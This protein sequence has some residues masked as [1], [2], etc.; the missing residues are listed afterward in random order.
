MSSKLFSYSPRSYTQAAPARPCWKHTQPIHRPTVTAAT[1]PDG[2]VRRGFASVSQALDEMSEGMKRLNEGTKSLNEG[3]KRLQS[4]HEDMSEKLDTLI[5]LA[6]AMNELQTR[7]SRW[8]DTVDMSPCDPYWLQ[9][10]KTCSCSSTRGGCC[11]C[12]R[13][14][15][16][17]D[18]SD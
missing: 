13:I 10:S 15:R 2:K 9:Q 3:M 1:G 5:Q 16:P 14:M 4:L 7:K 17:A 11:S 6:E 12:E 18:C 8:D